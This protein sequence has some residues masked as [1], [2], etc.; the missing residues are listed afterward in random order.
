MNGL[1]RFFY[2]ERLTIILLL[3]CLTFMMVSIMKF[4]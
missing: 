1:K 4:N 2:N 3:L